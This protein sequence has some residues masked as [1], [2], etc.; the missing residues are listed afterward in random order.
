MARQGLTDSGSVAVDQIEYARG[1]ARLIHNLCI[2]ISR[3]RRNFAGL[4]HHGAAHRQRRRDLTADLIEGPI[5]GRNQTAHTDGLFHHPVRAKIFGEGIAF[6]NLRGFGDV[7][8]SGIGLCGARQF[9][10]GTHFQANRLGNLAN[11]A[12]KNLCH[13]LEHSDTL[14]DGGLAK[15]FK[16]G[17][18]RGNRQIDIGF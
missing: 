4:K 12:L 9:D 16:R 18:G 17:L 11:A 14:F 3:Q 7:A 2:E 1:N 5:P 10:R 15:G 6:Q 13:P 8:Q